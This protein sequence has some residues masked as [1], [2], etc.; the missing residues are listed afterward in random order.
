M[1]N[2]TTSLPD[3]LSKYLGNLSLFLI[4]GSLVGLE[5][6]LLCWL[7]T[8]LLGEDVFVFGLLVILVTVTSVFVSLSDSKG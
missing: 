3:L 4:Y 8:T 1:K 7:R 2:S 5:I 6:T